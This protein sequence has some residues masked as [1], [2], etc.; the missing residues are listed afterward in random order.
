[1]SKSEDDLELIN[2]AVEAGVDFIKVMRKVMKCDK[3]GV[4]LLDCG[5]VIEGLLDYQPTPIPPRSMPAA[6]YA[7][8][9]AQSGSFRRMVEKYWRGDFD[10]ATETIIEDRIPKETLCAYKPVR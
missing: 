4:D 7:A 2:A 8:I 3:H 6:E 5:C 9:L 10:S 1:M